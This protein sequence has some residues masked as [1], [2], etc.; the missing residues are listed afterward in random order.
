MLK[1]EIDLRTE[2]A[3]VARLQANGIKEVTQ[4]A[5]PIGPGPAS[6]VL[7]G[8]S[9]LIEQRTQRLLQAQKETL[10]MK[11]SLEELDKQSIK[12]RNTELDLQA[13][14]VTLLNRTRDAAR[15]RATQ[16]AQQLALPA[17]RERGLQLLDDSVKA[18]E[19]QL[20]I[21][22]ALNG[23][24]ARGVRFLEK[25]SQEEKRQL[26]L[27]ITGERT[28]ALPANPLSEERALA[29]AAAKRTENLAIQQRIRDTSASTVLQVNLIKNIMQQMASIGEQININTEQELVNQRRLNRERKVRLGR[30]RQR[31]TREAVGSAVIGGAFP[32]LFGQGLGASIGGAAGGAAGG[33]LGGQFGFGLSLVGTQIGSLFDQLIENATNLGKALNPLTADVDQIIQKAGAANTE[34]AKTVKSLS[35][36]KQAGQALDLA[37]QKLAQ[38]IGVEGVQALESF[39]SESAK[40]QSELEILGTKVLAFVSGPLAAFIAEINKGLQSPQAQE[41]QTVNQARREFFA[42]T[43]SPEV[44]ALFEE[45]RSLEGPQAERNKRRIEIDKEIVE[46]V[47]KQNA[48]LERQATIIANNTD[49]QNLKKTF[50]E[51]ESVINGLIIDDLEQQ[52][53]ILNGNNSLLKDSVYEAVKNNIQNE[54]YRDL[55]KEQN[56]ELEDG[57]AFLRRRNSLAE[58]DNKRQ[59]ERNAA[60]R[61]AASE[62]EKA[63]RAARATRALSIEL[64][65]SRYL[66]DQNIAIAEARR[67]GNSELVYTLQI[68][69]ER[70][71]LEATILKIRNED[72][73]IEDKQLK[74]SIARE[75]AA[76][77]LNNL[78]Q[79]KLDRE[80]DIEDAVNKNLRSIQNEIELSQARLAGIEEQTK[81][82]QELA[83]IKENIKGINEDDLELIKERLILLQEQLASEK[84]I[85]EV[86]DIQKRTETAGAGLRAGFIGQAGQAFEQQLQQGSTAERATEIALLTQEMELAELQAQSMQNAVLGIGNAFATA[87][88]T[89]VSELIAGTK[90]AEEVFSDFLKGVGNALLQSAQ[91]MIATYIAI[92]IA[93]AFA[94]LAGGGA[95]DAGDAMDGGGNLP[96]IANPGE[97][98][99]MNAAG[100]LVFPGLA[101][102]GPVKADQPYIVGEEG[103]ELFIPGTSG[104]I[105]NN[106]Q[107]EAARAALVES[108]GLSEEEK[109]AIESPG[110][111]QRPSQLNQILKDSRSAVQTINQITKERET[112]SVNSITKELTAAAANGP[113]STALGSNT[114]T[115]NVLKEILGGDTSSESSSTSIE[116]VAQ[117]EAIVAA[118]NALVEQKIGESL[119]SLAEGGGEGG[120]GAAGSD[121]SIVKS[122]RDYIQKLTEKAGSSVT[123]NSTSSSFSDSRSAI[124][125]VTALNQTR[126]MLQST[127]SITKERSVER[128]SENQSASAMQPLDV[129]YESQVIN[130]VEYVTAEQH[131]RGLAEA[132]ER[133]RAMTLQTLQNSVKSRRKV[134]LA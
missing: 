123:N 67:D 98:V 130:N 94:G 22:Q 112:A 4:Y 68:H 44:T 58:L 25:Q 99:S 77:R 62:K 69:K 46:L 37:T 52:F 85:Q 64:Q 83:T 88:T 57:I 116:Q 81:L 54:Y 19:S 36:T 100:S 90:S 16:P 89:G 11:K 3:R 97:S 93:R 17:F 72:L 24:R 56:G 132:A 15:F 48:D 75:N 47:N 128:A 79:A 73:S 14:L 53:V 60:D 122:S 55:I 39:G 26:D 125:R 71:T 118:R 50:S 102:G 65:L 1:Q 5:G 7:G 101:K 45:R 40:L 80:K 117:A 111:S 31:R 115:N 95:P 114:T 91:Q 104:L 61:K 82:E 105:S 18:N 74:I 10:E 120:T 20:R 8:Q 92:G 127:S 32:A 129:R 110:T 9:T 86:R 59:R 107:F 30:Q 28:K 35:D 63:D 33:L 109:E 76:Q 43:A 6:S 87:M 84:A 108:A 78:E 23:E 134:G 121:S 34:F 49:L 12:N 96:L 27:G 119:E 106:D 133:G 124:D 38:E 131:R 103:A 29:V 66:T 41:I 51:Q 126:Q 113:V 2:N 42:G 13:E 21:E 70:Q